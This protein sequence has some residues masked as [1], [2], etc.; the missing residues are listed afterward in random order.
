VLGDVKLDVSFPEILKPLQKVLDCF[1]GDGNSSGLEKAEEGASLISP[2]LINKAVRDGK[3]RVAD[4][5]V[6][7][8]DSFGMVEESFQLFQAAELIG[9]KRI[10]GSGR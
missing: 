3:P 8:K 2:S 10:P 6:D 5:L 7:K 9:E 1:P 4:I